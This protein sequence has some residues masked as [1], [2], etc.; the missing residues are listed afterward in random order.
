MNQ[1]QLQQEDDDNSEEE[2]EHQQQDDD[3][4]MSGSSKD[5]DLESQNYGI[6][7]DGEKMY[8]DVN[9][10]NAGVQLMGTNTR[11]G[12]DVGVARGDITQNGNTIN[13]DLIQLP[14][15][16][17]F[18]VVQYARG[19]T[20]STFQFELLKAIMYLKSPP[21][22]QELYRMTNN[23]RR[24]R[25]NSGTH[26]RNSYTK[27]HDIAKVREFV[28]RNKK[29]HVSIFISE[30]DSTSNRTIGISQGDIIPNVRMVNISS[31]TN[32]RNSQEYHHNILIA[33]ITPPSKETKLQ[34][35]YVQ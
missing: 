21:E 32:S 24:K 4:S 3:D 14:L 30:R 6:D 10:D 29:K 23:Q 7:E 28:A 25:K 34:Y 5:G 22:E 19:H 15:Q 35:H 20:G 18:T 1:H 33:D 2:D 16:Y 11:K 9:R 31:T 27:A 26:Q 13:D 8:N 12:D 17:P